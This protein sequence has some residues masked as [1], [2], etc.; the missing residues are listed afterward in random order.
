MNEILVI[1]FLISATVLICGLITIYIVWLYG[2][3][4]IR[5]DIEKLGENINKMLEKLKNLKWSEK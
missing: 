5:E 1:G 2:S 3:K 4:E